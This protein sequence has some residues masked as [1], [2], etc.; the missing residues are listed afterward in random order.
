MTEEAV[1]AWDSRLQQLFNPEEHRVVSQPF[2]LLP[3]RHGDTKAPLANILTQ[4]QEVWSIPDFPPQAQRSR[5]VV[6]AETA[7]AIA[8]ALFGVAVLDDNLFIAEGEPPTWVPTPPEQP[9]QQSSQRMS[10]SS[11]RDSLSSQRDSLSSQRI[12]MSPIKP[13]YSMSP[14]KPRYSMSPLKPRRSMSPTKPSSSATLPSSFPFSSAPQSQS[15]AATA[16]AAQ[17]AAEAASQA[18]QRLS[19]LAADIDMTAGPERQHQ[20]LSYWPTRRGVPTENY[21]SSVLASST[22]HL[23]AIKERRERVESRRRKR[24]SQL[25]G[26][27]GSS[28][29]GSSQP[30]TTQDEM[31]DSAPGEMGPPAT[32]PLPRLAPPIIESSQ[33]SSPKRSQ[34]QQPFIF[35]SQAF[36]SQMPQTMSQPLAG[37]HGMRS[38]KKKGK[39]KSGF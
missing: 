33:P 34:P 2:S 21:V 38:P 14:I 7:E 16:A 39:R 8:R 4:L 24:R 26:G 23:D 17:E 20:V 28:N 12:S 1:A 9:T 27:T 36:S 6:L 11:Q 10:L 18:L 13:R 37:R 3:L 15:S 30:A 19:M 29:P 31:T 25:F 35:S 5:S 32:Q 22:K